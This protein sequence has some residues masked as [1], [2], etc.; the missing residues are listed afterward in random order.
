MTTRRMPAGR[1]AATST[2]LVP[3]STVMTQR[4]PCAWSS[5]SAAPCRPYPSLMRLGMYGTVSTPAAR[6]A[7]L[8]MAQAVT[9]SAS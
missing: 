7:R 1:A 3:Q 5:L 8:S 2:L 9:P 6:S 4:T